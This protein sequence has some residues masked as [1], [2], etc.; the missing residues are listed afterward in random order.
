[1]VED[2]IKEKS[3][4]MEKSEKFKALCISILAQ[5]GNCQE[6]QL[7]FRGGFQFNKGTIKTY[8]CI[9]QSN[10]TLISIP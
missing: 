2:S 6:S 5:S 8:T 10:S 1:M 7:A 4:D 3:Q 9:S